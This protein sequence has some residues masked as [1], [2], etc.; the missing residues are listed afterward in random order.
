MY[1]IILILSLIFIFIASGYSQKKLEQ[2]DVDIKTYSLY[3]AGNWEE[4]IKECEYAIDNSIDFFYLRL[5]LGI[6]YFNNSDY[7]KATNHFEKAIDFNP[8]DTLTLEYLYYSYLYSGRESDAQSLVSTMSLKL[9]NKLKVQ[10]KIFYGAYSEVG[11]TKNSN[12]NEQKKKNPISSQMSFNEQ[13]INDNSIYLNLSLIHQLGGRVKIFH[14][15]NNISVSSTKQISE[16]TLGQREF[17]LKTN[18]DEYYLNINFNLGYGFDLTTAFHYLNVKDE[19][20]FIQYNEMINPPQPYYAKSSENTNNFSTLISISKYIGYFKLGSKNYISNLNKATQV[21]S[22]FQVIFFPLG[23]LNLY[24]VTDATILSNK[25]WGDKFKSEGILD[26]KI[27]W[28]V[29]NNLWMEVGYTFG[30]IYN[31]NESD[32]FIVFNNIN[33]ISNRISANLIIP[34][35]SKM[36]FSLRY[37]YYNQEVISNINYNPILTQQVFSNNSNHKIIGGLKWTF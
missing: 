15:Y 19:D 18:Q 17:K 2:K 27:G 22:T 16:R 5:R 28:K 26:Q 3:L 36:E 8:S 25:V 7:L 21:Q 11:Y 31:Y 32:A 37:Q 9:K 1:K 14:G 12:I 4:L 35:S 10:N 6:A 30:K 20:I 34:I 29:F 33:K 24:S 13:K 23:N